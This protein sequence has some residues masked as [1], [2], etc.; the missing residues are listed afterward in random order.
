MDNMSSIV[1][2]SR[3][4]LARNVKNLPFPNRLNGEEGI[5]T[6][7]SNVQKTCNSLFSNK[8]YKMDS[9]DKYE[10]ESLVERHLI[11][12]NLQKSKYGGA[13]ISDSEDISVMVFEEDHLRIQSIMRGFNLEAAYNN[14]AKIDAELK[15]NVEIAFDQRLGY[16]TACPTNLG[17]AMRASVMMFLPG[18]T[19]LG[20]IENLI[21][22][23][24]KLG[25]TIRGIYG[26]GSKA[27]GY[28]Y[29]ISN[30]ASISLSET[31]ILDKIKNI[32]TQIID[33]ENDA[34]ERLKNQLGLDL[35]NEIMIS[36][37]ILKYACKMS[38]Q[39]LTQ[40]LAMIKLGVA[41]G[42]LDLDMDKLNSL[43]VITQPAMLCYLK[44]KELTPEQRDVYRA[45]ITKKMI[46]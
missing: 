2:S 26:E 41:L 33:L 14:V 17:S 31:E 11:S 27:E 1:V 32:V 22:Q 12:R 7:L 44:K 20:K 24:Q 46:G 42:Y 39:E 30:Q 43:S 38:S 29:Q 13:F 35:K 4:R 19:K 28:M 16:L 45:E 34:R 36:Y 37:G 6:L 15:K 21:V 5:Y 23:S 25:I 9:M 3:V 18:L 10:T 40:N 8:Y